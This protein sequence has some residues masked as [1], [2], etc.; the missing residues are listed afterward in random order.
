MARSFGRTWITPALLVA[1]GVAVVGCGQKPA[2]EQEQ[3]QAA[4]PP[5]PQAV[6]VAPMEGAMV[7]G[8]DVKIELAAHDVTLAP[9]GTMELGTGHLHL[10]INHDVTP[11]GDVIPTGEGI[12][13]LGQAQTEYTME[14]VAPGNYTVIAV[15]ADGAHVRLPGALTDT[16]HFM[17]H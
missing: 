9:A 16:V 14:G 4:A 13:H 1:A 2:Q 3:V 10:F 7:T 12:V 15:L 8:P 6:I 5:V 17:V 11:E